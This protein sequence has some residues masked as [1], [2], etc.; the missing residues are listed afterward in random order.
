MRLLVL[1]GTAF[2]SRAVAEEAVRRGHQV[3]CACRGSSPL[4]AGVRHLPLDRT[5]QDP[6]QVLE[7]TYDAVVDVATRPSW[8][9]AAVAATTAAHHVYVSSVSVYAD[10]TTPGGAPG[11]L[12][13]LDVIHEDV[14]L[15]ASPDAYGGMK[16]GCEEAVR[17]AEGTSLVVRPGLIVGP[18]DR[19]GR[20]TYWPVR[21]NRP[22]PVLAPAPADAPVQ[23]I[24]ARD[25]GAWLARCAEDRVTG[26]LDAV[27]E[28][29]DWRGF[30]GDV[31]AGVRT[32]PDL[33]WVGS[34]RLLELGVEPWA[35]PGSLPVWLPPTEYA[36][37]LAHDPGPAKAAGLTTRPVADT[38]RDTLAWVRSEPGV[39][40]GGLTREQ[41]AEVLRRA[42]AL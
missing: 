11:R 30:L 32:A 8:V 19:S 20:F 26:V 37:M 24:D 1:G 12:P 36:G 17:A 14:D 35:G 5:V 29:G 21:L 34:D 18:G 15:T 22:G 33:V 39:D 27:G 10:H 13:E 7:G 42:A 38:A 31:A 16:R 25:L 40:V 2:L 28:I 9:R 6:A 41:E 3:T 23:V 4:P